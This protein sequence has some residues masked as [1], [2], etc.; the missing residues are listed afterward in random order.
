MDEKNRLV[1]VQIYKTDNTGDTLTVALYRNGEIMHS[2][3]IT[4]PMGGIELLIDAETGNP[5]GI[6]TPGTT[7]TAVQQPPL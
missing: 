1:Q 2:R 6:I 7:Q 3:S 5:P 4:S